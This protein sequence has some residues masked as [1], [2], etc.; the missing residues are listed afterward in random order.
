MKPLPA[1]FFRFQ[2]C[3]MEQNPAWLRAIRIGIREAVLS[4][5]WEACRTR[6]QLIETELTIIV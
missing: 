1:V 5:W 3:V 4:K 6:K 2:A